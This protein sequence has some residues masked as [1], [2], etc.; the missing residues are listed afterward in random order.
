MVFTKSVSRAAC[1]SL[2]ATAAVS[3]VVLGSLAKAANAVSLDG[4]WSGGG[5]VTGIS[6]ERERVRCRVRYQRRS[7][8]VFSVNAVC[9][10]RDNRISQT[11]EVLRVNASRY[12]GDFY[13]AQFNISGRVR[14]NINGRSQFVTFRSDRGGGAVSLRKR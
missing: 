3:L 4:T 13:N 14:I 1:L 6:G 7:S 2:A 11:G 8:R 10:T 12:V 5:Y 9:A